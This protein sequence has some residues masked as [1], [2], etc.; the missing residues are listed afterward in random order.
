MTARRRKALA[1]GLATVFSAASDCGAVSLSQDGTGQALIY[2]YYSV[3][4]AQGNSFNT[5]LSVV[6][7]TDRA[8]AL[9]IRF[10]EGRNSREVMSF[11]LFLSPNDVWTSAVV[12]RSAGGAA[13]LITADTSC[14]SRGASIEVAN[15]GLDFSNALYSGANDDGSGTGLDRT[16]EG[17]VEMIEMGTLTGSW[18][19]AV[20]HTSTSQPSNCGV[21][22]GSTLPQ[23][24]PPTGGLSGTLTL[25]N[26]NSGLDFGV[27]AE[28]LADLSTQPFYR[29]A[30][31]PYP[32]FN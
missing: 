11:N 4:S 5:Y 13:Y 23:V 31:D 20:T 24:K 16:R 14:T 8:K 21:V 29:P 9:R 32:D 12:P 27:S 28:A 26:V 10:R 25:I 2:P 30:T 7:H 6:N 3:Q 15:G 22:Q 1:A 19:A 18:A 17:F